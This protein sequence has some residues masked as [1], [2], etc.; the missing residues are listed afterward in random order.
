[1]FP[2]IRNIDFLMESYNRYFNKKYNINNLENAP[3]SLWQ[4]NIYP[5][6]IFEK[7]CGWL[8]ILIEEVYP[9]SV[10]AP[11]ETHWG[12]MGG[13]TERAIAI[14]NAIEI[15]ENKNE[16]GIFDVLHTEMCNK[17][18]YDKKLFLNYYDANV[19]TKYVDNI[20]TVE[21]D[22]MHYSMF[23]SQYY[24]EE[25]KETYACERICVK[26]KN[27][28]LFQ[29][30]TRDVVYGFEIEAEDPRITKVKDDI[31]VVFICLSPYE[32]QDRCIAITKFDKFE[33]IYLRVENMEMNRI[34]KNWAP[35]EKDG[36]LYFVYNYEPLI[37]L[38]YDFNNEGI[39]KIIY[40][41]NNV[42]L[43][44]KTETTYLRGGSNL[45]HYKDNYYIGGCHS[46]YDD[47]RRFYH[48]THI[49][50]LDVEKWEIVFL[51]KPIIYNYRPSHISSALQ[52]LPL[53]LK[54]ADFVGDSNV[55][56]RKKN[57]IMCI[58][59]T[60]I[61]FDINPNCIQDPVSLYIRN[62][63]YYI[64]VNIRDSISHLYEIEFD[65]P[66]GCLKKYEMGKLQELTKS[67]TL[68]LLSS[69]IMRLPRNTIQ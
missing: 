20:T 63:K 61:M 12:V 48:F 66:K 36:E 15:I 4:T 43:P 6:K 39:C 38:K 23:K 22:D 40:K 30:R 25:T 58:N 62:N 21:I 3:L 14:F 44:I 49:I 52:Q 19:Y 1:M 64:T 68:E 34:E 45:L 55:Q 50:L 2:T 32:G 65:I 7:L 67:Y 29:H 54:I 35:F 11:Y 41:Q 24:K 18:Q 37:I 8:S 28:L 10:E 51:S 47:G 16:Y 60:T 42:E 57:D 9:W 27:G 46:R 31:Y 17:M 53:S 56:R 5:R 59:G 33:P 69:L 26:N 13:Y